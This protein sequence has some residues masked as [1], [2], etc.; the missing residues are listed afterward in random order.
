MVPRNSRF[1][2]CVMP[3][4]NRRHF[5]PEAIRLFLAQDY[6]EKELIILDDGEHSVA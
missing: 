4:A 2:S 5:V 3:T 1:V 6:A